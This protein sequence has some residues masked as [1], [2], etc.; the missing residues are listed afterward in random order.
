VGNRVYTDLGDDELYVA[1]P[2]RTLALL[3]A[4]LGTIA[5]ANATLRDYHGQRRKDLATA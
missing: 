2:G 4:E 5:A 3:V 1:L